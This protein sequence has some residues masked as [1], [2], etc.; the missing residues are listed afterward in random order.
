MIIDQ[1]IKL[2]FCDVLLVPT[3]SDLESR[4]QVSLSRSFVFRWSKENIKCVPICAA[5]MHKTGTLRMS[6]EMSSHGMLTCLSKHINTVDINRYFSTLEEFEVNNIVNHISFSSGSRKED[7]NRI[8]SLLNEY[9]GVKFICL[10]VANGYCRSFLN[11]IKDFRQDYPDKVI[12]AGNVVTSDQACRIIESGADIVKVGIGSGS[13]CTTRKMTGV[14]YPQ[15]SAI[16][17]MHYAVHKCGGLIMSDGGCQNPGDISKAF[18]IN[19]DFVM[20]GG[21][22]AGHDE[23]VHEDSDDPTVFYGMSSYHAM[24]SHYG[25]ISDYRASEGKIVSISS[26]GP[27]SNTLKEIMGGIRS[28]CT[29]LNSSSIDQISKNANFIQVNRQLNGMFS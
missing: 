5:N 27:V 8:V 19:A 11:F 16:R 3:E 17:D 15:W 9:P 26:K 21:M 13:V 28:A 4:K 6:R 24:E 10:D 22:L 23:C 7:I 12:I 29:Y 20:L 14:G 18:A 1:N 25:T 2:D